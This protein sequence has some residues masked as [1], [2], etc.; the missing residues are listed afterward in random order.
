V[1]WLIGAN[2]LND[3]DA[4]FER[5]ITPLQPVRPNSTIA[6]S[7][8]GGHPVI[9]VVQGNPDDASLLSLAFAEART[10]VNFHFV[11]DGNEARNYLQGFRPY[12]NRAQFPF[13][14]LLLV[15]LRLHGMS[16]F[17]L[18]DWVRLDPALNKVRVGV[19]CEVNQEP[20]IEKA[21]A[22][23]ADFHVIKRCSFREMVS[24]AQRLSE[25]AALSVEK[26]TL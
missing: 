7:I 5:V 10:Q 3:L 15:D 1:P 24:M 14:N 25:C 20:D 21:H 17:E 18:L 6:S 4:N 22:L 23:G 11:P 12:D 2:R 8:M 9:L 13:P 16:A 26:E 19:L